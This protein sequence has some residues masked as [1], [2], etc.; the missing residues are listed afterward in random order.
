MTALIAWWFETIA[1]Y[2]SFW[3]KVLV[4]P[5]NVPIHFVIEHLLAMAASL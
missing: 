5:L 4:A 3:D 1:N 2:L